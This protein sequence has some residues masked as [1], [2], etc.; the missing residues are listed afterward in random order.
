MLELHRHSAEA[1]PADYLQRVRPLSDPVRALSTFIVVNGV[2]TAVIMAAIRVGGGSSLSVTDALLVCSVTLTPLAIW[3][4]LAP[5]R[6]AQVL[7]LRAFR[8]DA[9][10]VPL[11]RLLR[12]AIGSRLR[13][14]GIRPPQERVSRLT[15][16]LLSGGIGF[17][18]LGTE[19]FELE[20]SDYNWMPRL[21]AS[22]ARARLVIID[23]RD[24]TELVAD[25]IRLSYLALGSDRCIFLTDATRPESAWV[26]LIARLLP[27]ADDDVRLM[28]LRYHGDSNP[29]ASEFV[30]NAN[31]LMTRAGPS[32]GTVSVAALAFVRSRVPAQNWSTSLM[33]REWAPMLLAAAIAN[34]PAL[35]FSST[36]AQLPSAFLGLASTASYVGA[37][38]RTFREAR[39]QGR[40]RAV[41]GGPNPLWRPSAILA[42]TVAGIAMGIAAQVAIA[43][44]RLQAVRMRANEASVI[45]TLRSI[46]SAQATYAATCGNGGYAS[47]LTVL[48]TPPGPGE[49]AFV[50]ESLGSSD[51]PRWSGYTVLLRAARASSPGPSDCVGRP[52]VT[53]WYAA[54]IPQD[55]GRTGSRSFATTTENILWQLDAA[56]APQ[57]P[58]GPPATPLSY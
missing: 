50:S 15:R 37:L 57:E 39:H 10:A 54:A 27:D 6:R 55:L 46:M 7:Y 25:E 19:Q 20:A 44:P 18:Y 36:T 12:A 31:R 2:A 58:F 33:E 3:L 4:L 24:L 8:S 40:F 41:V 45:G 17:R 56:T 9:T 23:V 38:I 29:E 35:I 21:L 13:L 49:A 47:R 53:D 43:L 28:M 51:A 11:R 48:G 1:P 14:C 26:Q 22:L 5:S 32:D 42:L 30:R 34:G 16:L 52:T